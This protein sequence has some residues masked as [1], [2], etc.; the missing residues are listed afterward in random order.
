M[1]KCSRQTQPTVAVFFPSLFRLFTNGKGLGAI[2]YIRLTFL[3]VPG[4]VLTD[5]SKLKEHV[6]MVSFER[7]RLVLGGERVDLQ[8]EEEECSERLTAISIFRRSSSLRCRGVRWPKSAERISVALGGFG[9]RDVAFDYPGPRDGLRQGERHDGRYGEI[10]YVRKM[11]F[12]VLC[13]RRL[14]LL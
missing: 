4:L 12:T 1:L 2:A 6:M 14:G 9:A 13:E 5:L 10:N 8:R 7:R 11:I 3:A